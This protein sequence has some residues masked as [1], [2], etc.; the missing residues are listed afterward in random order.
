MVNEEGIIPEFFIH[1]GGLYDNIYCCADPVQIAIELHRE[2]APPGNPVF[3]HTDIKVALFFVIP[4]GPGTKKDDA[5]GIGSTR[6]DLNN[7]LERGLLLLPRSC[8]NNVSLP[9]FVSE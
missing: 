3:D 6:D 7:S 8:R 1:L 2:I 9:V 5:I 4:P